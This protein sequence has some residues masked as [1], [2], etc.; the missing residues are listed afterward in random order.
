MGTVRKW[1]RKIDDAII[2]PVVKTVENI[3][4]NPVALA[5]V[6]LS[7]AA[8]GIGTAIGSALGATGAAATAVGNAVVGGALAEASGGD[9]LKGAVAGAAG[10]LAPGVQSGIAET[11]GGGAAGNIAAGALTSG[12]M[13]EISG[14]DF[15]QGA[16]LGGIGTG[17]NQAKLAAAEDY[18]QSL[19][20]GYETTPAP[21]EL[22]I[23]DV[24]AAENPVFVPPN[25]TFTPDYSLS[26]GA[27]VIPE[28]GAQGIQVPTI[29]QVID[30]L[31]PDYSLPVPNAGL[32][33]VMPTAPNI[34]AMGGGQGITVP[35][36]GG[37]LTESGVIPVNFT[38]PLG[39]QSSFINQPAPD[40]SVNIPNAPE[41]TTEDIS[42]TL[43]AL[44][45]AKQLAPVV[46]GAA[47]ANEVINPQQE[48]GPTGFQIVPIPADWRSP[49]YNMAFTPSAPID[50]GTREL[51]RGTQWE[52]PS[53][54]APNAY[55][56]SN[57]IN[58]LNYQSQPFVQNVSAI[59]QVE[60][61]MPDI[62]DVFRAPTTVGINDTIGN[63]NGT[64]VSIADIIA[65]I[66]SGQNYSG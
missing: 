4:E 48:E 12:T 29:N 35:V 8:P 42:G 52:S 31:Q 61:Q 51:L 7:V 14:G 26:T 17:I 18:L 13:A 10:A 9:F 33:L 32:G 47:L 55:T 65:G 28:M 23:L 60:M 57:L 66:Q 3:I 56:L 43:K 21:T 36:S 27:P 62:L 20:S 45:V 64:P 40:V 50:F 37:T 41:A 58:T 38:P 22:D 53:V 46:V 30:V 19:P 15:A 5:S 63:L 2:Q 24:I 6:A 54:Q 44:D 1:G 59:P 34:D 25:T 39:D 16:L 49:E 11:L